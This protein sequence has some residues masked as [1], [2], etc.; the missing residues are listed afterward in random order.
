MMG[1]TERFHGSAGSLG[2]VPERCEQQSK[3]SSLATAPLCSVR[4]GQNEFTCHPSASTSQYRREISDHCL[5]PRTFQQ[6]PNPDGDHWSL[7]ARIAP[8]WSNT[9]T[10]GG[11]QVEAT[12]APAYTHP[13][14]GPVW[15]QGIPFN[16]GPTVKRL[17]PPGGA[18][19]GPR[20]SRHRL[21]DRSWRRT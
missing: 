11:D 1:N 21:P 3:D 16:A 4:V 9:M 12:S 8:G 14:T 10:S 20:R 13:C 7:P 6:S 2:L 18:P 5:H 19:P 15:A 17:P